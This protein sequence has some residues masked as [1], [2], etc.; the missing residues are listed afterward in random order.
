[1]RGTN[2]RTLHSNVVA[3]LTLH[4]IIDDIN[5]QKAVSLAKLADPNG[6]RTIGQYVSNLCNID[7]GMLTDSL[8]ARGLDIS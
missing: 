1:M 7:R 5:N 8:A 2:L 6:E 3:V 4:L